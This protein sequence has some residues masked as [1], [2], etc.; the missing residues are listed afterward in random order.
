MPQMH[1]TTTIKRPAEAVFNLIADL[2][3]YNRWLSPSNLFAQT[4]QISDNPIKLGSTYLDQGP[5]STMQGKITEFQPPT[6]LTFFQTTQFKLL[7][8]PAGLDI[9]IQY[10]LENIDNGT[11]VNR[12]TTVNPKGIARLAQPILL[13]SIKA[14][15]ERILR[16]MKAYLESQGN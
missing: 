16:V 3:N 1:F 4:M 14:E 11:R 5:Q 6:R 9:E 8:F 12:N 15:N 10:V 7:I 13:N 2:P